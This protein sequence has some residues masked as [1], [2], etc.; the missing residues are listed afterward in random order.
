[1]SKRVV[2]ENPVDGAA[3]VFR[4]PLIYREHPLKGSARQAVPK[5]PDYS[6]PEAVTLRAYER[7]EAPAW[8]V[9]IYRL[10]LQNGKLY[11]EF[12]AALARI[13]P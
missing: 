6:T 11:R 12:Q 10:L 2:I 8:T 7:G 9:A 13:A 1:M 4:I 3:W 5:P